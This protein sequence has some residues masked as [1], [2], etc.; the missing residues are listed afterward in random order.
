M[1]PR[2]QWM[3]ALRGIAIMLVIVWH[4]VSLTEREGIGVPDWVVQA[5]NFFVPYRMPALMFLSGLL[6]ASSLRKPAFQYYEGK[7][8]LLI[9]PYIVWAFIFIMVAGTDYPI[10]HPKAWFPLGHLWFL[11][12]I[13]GYYFIAPLVRRVPAW[14]VSVVLLVASAPIDGAY[15]VPKNFLYFGAFFF[16]GHALATSRG[17]FDRILAS[18]WMPAA[19]LL[20]GAF[21]TYA[22]LV[23]VEHQWQYAPLNVAGIVASAWL[24][25]RVENHSLVRPLRCVG[26]QSIIY[27]VSH[28]PVITIFLDIARAAGVDA[29]AVLIP[30]SISV[31]LF[32]G[33]VLTHIG[34]TRAGRWLFQMPHVPFLS[35]E[36]ETPPSP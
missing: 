9:W 1:K 5:N 17:G 7:I 24:V 35:R 18:R 19:L 29:A 26:R 23:D 22:M 28:F 11:A 8:R 12:F 21:G 13:A 3:D 6:L 30:A 25:K 14:I 15:G 36:Y 31:A 16:L 27:Y 20:A 34:S 33:Y 10:Y 2:M 32:T 4:A